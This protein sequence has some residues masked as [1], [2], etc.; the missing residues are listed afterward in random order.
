MSTS[1]GFRLKSGWATAVLLLGPIEAPQVLCRRIVT[2][3]DPEV[4]GTEQPYHAAMGRLEE[5]EATIHSRIAIVRRVAALSVKATL[6]DFAAT[7]HRLIRAGLV[8][9]SLTDPRAI[10]NPHIRAHALEGQLFRKVLA[11][12]LEANGLACSVM[13]ERDAYSAAATTLAQAEDEVK[14]AVSSLGRSL[15]GPWRA[16]EKLAALAAWLNLA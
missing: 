8:V 4:R 6:G 1:V 14:R 11:G 15:G 2:L 5:D 12:E 16:D 9:G 3:S 7:G 13:R 10:S